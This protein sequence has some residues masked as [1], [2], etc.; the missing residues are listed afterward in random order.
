MS[1]RRLVIPFA[2]GTLAIGCTKPP[3]PLY[4]R[5]GDL[6]ALEGQT[7]LD[8]P[9]VVELNPGDSFPLVVTVDGPLVGSPP[10]A[11]PVPLVVKQRFFLRISKDG[12]RTSRDGT[13]TDAA[14]APGQFRMGVGVTK[15]DG[16][17]AEIAIRTPGYPAH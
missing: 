6:H 14:A 12:L 11:T 10:G 4:V 15:K 16:V 8:R 5:P 9:I 13:F 1:L 17:R 2:L 3:P 7:T